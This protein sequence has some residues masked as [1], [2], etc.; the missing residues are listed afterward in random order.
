MVRAVTQETMEDRVCLVTGASSGIGLETARGL[1]RRG[2]TVLLHGRSSE[3]TS[4]AV[5]DVRASTDN[6]Q[7]H[8]LLAD[9]SSLAEVR[10]LAAAVAERTD[11]LSVLVNNAG[12]WH[13]QRRLSADGFEDTF[14]VN[15]L[16]PFLLTRELL[17]L[18]RAASGARVVTVSSRL[19]EKERAFDFDAVAEPGA[20]HGSGMRAYRQSKLANVMFAN[21]LARR[22]AAHGVMSNSVHPGDVATDVARDSPVLSWLLRNVAR[23]FLAS[24]AEGAETSIHV[25]TSPALDGATGGYYRDGKKR[26]QSDAAQ[27]RSASARLWALS[28][29]L[30]SKN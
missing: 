14:A 19:H 23:P 4:A 11:T 6:R 13:Q 10:A 27:D 18:L 15:Y 16:A 29:A 17:P 24:P 7:V 28:E 25:A 12:L 8:G 22:E 30:V 21:E 2:A 5:E 20:A 3:R 1:A 9:F 26:A